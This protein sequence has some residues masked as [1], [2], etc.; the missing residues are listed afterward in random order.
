MKFALSTPSPAGSFGSTA[1]YGETFAGPGSGVQGMGLF[2]NT[3]G[4]VGNAAPG[5]GA[6]GYF[7]GGTTA[8]RTLGGVQLPGSITTRI[9]G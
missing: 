8:L 9:T 5:T 2:P 7:T 1:V 4:V 6:G 3:F